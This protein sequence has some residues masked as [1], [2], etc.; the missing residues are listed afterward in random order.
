M[1]TIL[2]TRLVPAVKVVAQ[3]IGYLVRFDNQ[4]SRCGLNHTSNFTDHLLLDCTYV[5]QIRNYMFLNVHLLCGRDLAFA[6]GNLSRC[7]LVHSLL[8]RFHPDLEVYL[9]GLN[10]QS[11]FVN[12]VFRCIQRMYMTYPP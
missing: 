11:T 4:C 10:Q 1:T 7:D 2:N 5:S 8:G 9:Q 3:L 6:L 12:I